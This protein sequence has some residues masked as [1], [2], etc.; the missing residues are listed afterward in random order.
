[1]QGWQ[2]QSYP[3]LDSS[4]STQP[5]DIEHAL[6]LL[7]QLGPGN[8]YRVVLVVSWKT[9]LRSQLIS[10]WKQDPHWLFIQFSSIF[11]DTNPAQSESYQD[12]VISHL[13]KL[14]ESKDHLALVLEILNPSEP[15]V[16]YPWLAW[17]LNYL[18]LNITLVISCA[19][20]PQDLPL[21][22]LRVRRQLLE[23]MLDG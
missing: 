19:T 3:C 8:P 14:G 17:L 6:E 21:S 23:I 20:I 1:M 11:P 22:R 18:P 2:T 12:R 9:Y 10:I 7:S 5:L 13:N 16:A 15:P 4:M